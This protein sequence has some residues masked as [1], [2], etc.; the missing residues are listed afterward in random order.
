MAS[1][2]GNKI[3]SKLSLL[4]G[5]NHSTFNRRQN[6]LSNQLAL[7]TRE[8]C[9]VTRTV[10][11]QIFLLCGDVMRGFFSRHFQPNTAIYCHFP[12]LLMLHVLLRVHFP[13]TKS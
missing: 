9:F 12:F 13:T 6:M 2:R 1:K 7:K 8:T 5:N 10:R 4:G 3:N 11:L